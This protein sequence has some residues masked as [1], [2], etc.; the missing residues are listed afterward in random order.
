MRKT[1][2]ISLLLLIFLSLCLITFSLLSLSGAAAD[3]NLSQKAADH[4]AEYYDAV[5][6]ANR[7]LSFMDNH[8]YQTA[9]KS[10]SSGKSD[11]TDS[12]SGFYPDIHMDSAFSEM[13]STEFTGTDFFFE[14]TGESSSLSF[15]VPFSDASDLLLHVSLELTV[16]QTDQDTFYEITCWKVISSETWNPDRSMNLMRMTESADS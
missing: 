8:F 6:Q 15:S 5:S 2:G 10:V 1:T 7:I 4:T 3:E 12:L 9:K 16:P 14:E 13:L 11:K